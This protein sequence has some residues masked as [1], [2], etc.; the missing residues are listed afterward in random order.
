VQ[1]NEMIVK[2][3]GMDASGNNSVKYYIYHV[4]C[5]GRDISPD[6]MSE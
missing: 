3:L 2:E 5:N 4:L 1:N 6:G